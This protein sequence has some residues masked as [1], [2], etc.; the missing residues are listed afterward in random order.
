MDYQQQ[1]LEALAKA[2]YAQVFAVLEKADVMN[3]D[4]YALQKE[5]VSGKHKAVAD[6]IHIGTQATQL[7]RH[8]RTVFPLLHLTE[9]E[10][11]LLKQWAVL[12]TASHQ[13][14]DFLTWIGDTDLTYENTLL[15]LAEKGWL[16][17]EDNLAY[18][19]HPF[20]QLFLLEELKPALPDCYKMW[21][22]FTDLMILKEVEA[23]PSAYQ[24]TI[25][26]GEAMAQRIDYT[27]HEKKQGV[28]WDRIH[29]VYKSLDDYSNAIRC[30][31]Q[32]VAFI[33]VAVGKQHKSYASALNNVASLYDSVGNYAEALPLYEEVVQIRK[34]VLGERH[35]DY[36][37]SLNDLAVL[38]YNQENYTKALP[39]Y[40][41]A[42]QIC[43]ETLGKQHPHYASALHN[44]ASLYHQQ[45]NYAD[46]L[47]L[48]EEA[49]QIQK[50]TLGKQHPDYAISLNNLAG[51]YYEQGNYTKALPLY[52]EAAHIQKGI[53]GNR[54]ADYALSLHNIGALYFEQEDYTQARTYLEE[55][56]SI[57]L[58]KLG[59][60]HPHTQNAKEWLDNLPT[61]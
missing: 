19:L 42:L 56:Y 39:L 37:Q 25:A 46:A 4:L 52:E 60:Q 24:W 36:A 23:N 7:Y 59:E 34:E 31:K 30:A 29:H 47:L 16:Q 21:D 3:Q 48:Y 10:A 20:L 45:E 33:E 6:N 5:F 44:L 22:Y 32:S 35:L 14:S 12:P 26:V 54:H 28:L 61:L 2:G 17:T 41:E 40:E 55:A 50:N 13:A 15:A 11:W 27:N 9:D 8:F 1:I 18:A 38:Y 49:S 58:E 43:E 57:F 53:V 51:L